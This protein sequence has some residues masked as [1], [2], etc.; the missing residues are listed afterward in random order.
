LIDSARA[1]IAE[2]DAAG[3]MQAAIESGIAKRKIES[4]A[5]R[6]QA[7]IDSGE[8]VIVG[9]N[10]YQ[11]DTSGEDNVDLLDVDNVAVLKE[12]TER[13]QQLRAKR[14]E[15]KAQAALAALEEGARGKANLLALSIDAMRAR[16][17]VGEVSFALEKVF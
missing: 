5:A 13:L 6:R 3:G 2:V 7:R 8:E 11:T 10:K 1:V 12:Q 14:D 16:C 15:K 4:A 17:S 9:V